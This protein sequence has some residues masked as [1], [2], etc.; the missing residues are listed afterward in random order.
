M[1]GR[2][3]RPKQNQGRKR[4]GPDGVHQVCDAGSRRYDRYAMEPACGDHELRSSQVHKPIPPSPLQNVAASTPTGLDQGYCLCASPL[5]PHQGGPRTH[6]QDHFDAPQL[7]GRRRTVGLVLDYNRF[8]RRWQSAGGNS[9]R[10]NN[11]D[12]PARKVFS[13]PAGERYRP[14]LFPPRAN[15]TPVP[16]GNRESVGTSFG[17]GSHCIRLACLPC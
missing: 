1:L 7:V 10:S 2:S 9:Q 13:Y 5:V 17:R 11:H 12:N 3:H 8:Q 16:Y 4:H 15:A 14:N 6:R